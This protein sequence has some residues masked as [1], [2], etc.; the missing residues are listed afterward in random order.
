MN[1]VKR[2]PYYLLILLFLTGCGRTSLFKETRILMDTFVEVS[3]FSHEEKVAKEAMKETFNEIERIEGL[4]NRHN[5]ESELSKINKS[6]GRKEVA[7]HP[8]L[9]KIIERAIHYSK[10]SEG[11]F[12]I[13]VAPLVDLWSSAR[14][15]NLIPEEEVTERALEHVGYKNIVIDKESSSIRFLDDG[16]KIDLGGIVKGYAADRAKELLLSKGIENALINIGGNIFALGNPP[17]KKSWHIG[18]QHP[19]DKNKIIYRLSLKNRAV[20]TSGD[21]ERF[22]ILNGKRFSHIIDPVSGRPSEGIVSVTVIA[23]SAEASD[24]LS[25]IVFVMGVEKGLRLMESFKGV[26]VFIFDKDEELT[27]YP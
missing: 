2:A 6:A 1:R 5:E 26:E 4:F 16:L 22:F 27:R 13:T 10:V 19:R 17:G 7:I 25:T 12:D 21:Y 3:F 24:A 18:I 9:F 23:D 20:S 11:S 15:N 14:K 8:E